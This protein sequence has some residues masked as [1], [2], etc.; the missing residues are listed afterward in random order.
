MAV[1]DGVA[2]QVPS[3][4]AV[5]LAYVEF[6]GSTSN[7][8]IGIASQVSLARAVALSSADVSGST[9]KVLL[10]IVVVVISNEV[11]SQDMSAGALALASVEY[12]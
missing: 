11:V 7:V 4:S 5:A 8:L 10:V 2:F 6:P 9:S 1:S 3:T 12:C